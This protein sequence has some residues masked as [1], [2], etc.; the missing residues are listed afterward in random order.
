[1][2]AKH[3]AVPGRGVAG[4][5]VALGL[6]PS[7][8]PACVLAKLDGMVFEE[9][10]R[11]SAASWGTWVGTGGS[12]GPAWNSRDLEEQQTGASPP[13]S[14]HGQATSCPSL[15]PLSIASCSPPLSS[16]QA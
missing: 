7:T 16:T 15:Q 12:R 8:V 3:Q 11:S 5:P 2:G 1:M 13:A 9:R 6:V 4:C 14:P 10:G